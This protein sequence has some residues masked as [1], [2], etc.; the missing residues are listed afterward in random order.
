MNASELAQRMLE[1]ER[2]KAELD[3]LTT[4]IEDAVMD[5]GETQTV[6]KVRASY[7]GGRKTY[8]YETAGQNAPPSIIE[9]FTEEV[10]T[11]KTDWRSICKKAGIE[12]VPFRQSDPSVRVKLL[13]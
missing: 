3:A 7:S 13:S 1:W 4:E 5:L 10:T 8:D 9:D 2:V 6:G 12:D 11:I